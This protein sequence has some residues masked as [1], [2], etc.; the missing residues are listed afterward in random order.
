MIWAQMCLTVNPAYDHFFLVFDLDCG[1][2]R[3]RV[4]G[5]VIFDQCTVG[6]GG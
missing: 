1:R 3:D 4:V 5:E 2:A 6:R